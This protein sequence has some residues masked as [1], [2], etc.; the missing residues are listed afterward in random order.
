MEM[1]YVW[2]TESPYQDD[3]DWR[4]FRGDVWDM[5]LEM[6]GIPPGVSKTYA[7]RFKHRWVRMDLTGVEPADSPAPDDIVL[8]E[9]WPWWMSQNPSAPHY[10]RPAM[11]Q[12][13]QKYKG[14]PSM[15][16]RLDWKEF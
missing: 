7:G 11:R 9:E 4:R 12:W 13:V 3:P 1:L 8:P 14:D 10:V 16:F 2:P 5:Y 6:M 15:A